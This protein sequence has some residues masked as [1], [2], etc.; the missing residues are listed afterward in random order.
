MRL[1][2]K[3]L[4]G[5]DGRAAVVVEL[6]VGLGWSYSKDPAVTTWSSFTCWRWEDVERAESAELA[7]K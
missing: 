4:W 6:V 7:V 5:W 3:P 2:L 1:E